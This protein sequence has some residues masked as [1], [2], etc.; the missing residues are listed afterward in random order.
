MIKGTWLKDAY[1]DWVFIIVDRII[2]VEKEKESNIYTIIFA[3]DIRRRFRDTEIQ[4][5]FRKEED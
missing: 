5:I 1:G 3:D 4:K 2:L